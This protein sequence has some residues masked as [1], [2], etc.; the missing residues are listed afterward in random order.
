MAADAKYLS[1]V[2]LAGSRCSVDENWWA[3]MKGKAS[4]SA[5]MRHQREGPLQVGCAG[6]PSYPRMRVLKLGL[7]FVMTAMEACAAFGLQNRLRGCHYVCSS[8]SFKLCR[9]RS[10]RKSTLHMIASSSRRDGQKLR[11]SATEKLASLSST[12]FP[13]KTTKPRHIKSTITNSH[14]STWSDD[15]GEFDYP[16]DKANFAKKSPFPMMPS[17]LFRNLALSQ[18]ELLSHSLVSNDKDSESSSTK[19]GTPKTSSMILYLPKEN[20]IT[21]QLE[22]VTG[23]TYPSPSSERVF[24]ASDSSEDGPQQPQILPPRSALRLPGSRN[25][26]E[27]IPS[28]PF[29]SAS[30]EEIA[31]LNGDVMFTS[32]AQ[33]SSIGVSVVEEISQEGSNGLKPALLSVTLFSGL[34]TLGVLMIWPHTSKDYKQNNWEWTENDKLQVSRAAKS[35]ALALSMDN[36]LTTS[37]VQSEQFRMAFADS[38]HQVKSPLQALRTFGKLLQR[39][40]AEDSASGPSMRRVSKDAKSDE[41][42]SSLGRRQRQALRLAEDMVKQS[43]RVADL[44]Q[45]MD[46]FIT[47]Q[48]LLPASTTTAIDLYR[49]T[50]DAASDA[51]PILGDF[52]M[53]MVFPQDIIGPLVYAS[54][55]ISRE[56]GIDLE[57]DGF[58]QDADVPGC[59]V[60]TKYLI[61]AVTNVLDN[62]IKYVTTKKRGRGRPSKSSLPKIKVTLTANEP[63]LGVGCT[64]SV[65]DNGPGIE[66]GDRERLFE[67]GYRGRQVKDLVPGSGIGLNMSKTF[68]EKMGGS[69]AFL[70]DGPSNLGGATIRIMLF[71]EPAEG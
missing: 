44:I 49:Q 10:M 11:R 18:F 71:R 42:D 62:A 47:D 48:Y 67:R 39:Q 64:L 32:M 52:V 3:T 55:A 17:P 6:A 31:D 35:L 41:Y 40:L 24:I 13:S 46:A 26:K 30:N 59:K 61:E 69:I 36:E 33:D 22:F 4:E 50:N 5:I 12:P 56:S 63:P 20:Q 65:E 1:E 2:N 70:K 27:L 23:I 14:N 8:E 54:Q 21:G 58:D 28:Y 45:P 66:E 43:E 57:A 60:C 34:D 68:I 7:F 29:I 16:P 51:M 19:S 38:L 15:M 53:E 25:A 37:Q 9:I